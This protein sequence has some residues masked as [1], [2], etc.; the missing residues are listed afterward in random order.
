[1]LLT[2]PRLAA[3]TWLKNPTGGPTIFKQLEEQGRQFLANQQKGFRI[4]RE[5]KIIYLLQVF[6]FDK[7]HFDTLGGGALNFILPFLRPEDREFIKK[8]KLTVEY[9][10]Y[11]WKSNDIK[12]VN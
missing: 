5:K 2:A 10:D 4:D 8:E 9:L 1:M 11:N 7:K 6:K 12:N 3:S